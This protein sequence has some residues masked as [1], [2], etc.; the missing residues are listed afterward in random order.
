MP[1][2]IRGD[3]IQIVKLLVLLLMY[4]YTVS[5]IKSLRAI[6]PAV[7]LYIL[8]GIFA[9]LGIASLLFTH[10]ATP[11]LS[12]EPE[13]STVTTP[14]LAQ[15]D[16]TASNGRAVKFAPNTQPPGSSMWIGA[17]QN[18]PN[19]SIPAFLASSSAMGPL[20]VRRT[21]TG[22]AAS[23]PSSKPAAIAGDL[24][25]GLLSFYSCKVNGGPAQILSG[26]EDANLRALFNSLPHDRPTW[27]TMWHEPENDIN[28]GSFTAQQFRD[29][30]AHIWDVKQSSPN[31]ANIKVGYIAMDYW[32]RTGTTFASNGDQMLPPG[33]KYDYLAVD[34]YNVATTSGRTNAGTDP[35]F[36]NWY[37]WAK[38]KGKPLI[39][40][41]FGRKLNPNDPNARAKDLLDSETWLTN[42]GFNMFL[43][44]NGSGAQGDWKL[45]SAPDLNA[46]R[47]ISSRG[48]QL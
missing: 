20:T 4:Y 31:A 35:Q 14:A 23:V 6:P 8:L 24:A 5:I 18:I 32:W 36:Q 22:A 12:L 41:E 46:W 3:R 29:M 48:T 13:N 33:G 28:G 25:A 45:Y 43:Y 34:D 26:S 16:P 1:C 38:N 42:H 21:F 37:N 27:F 40:A 10:A 15:N 11:A 39:V 2:M 7:Y 47:A 30:I 44:W 17:A 19:T 9:V